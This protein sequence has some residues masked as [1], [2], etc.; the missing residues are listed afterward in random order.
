MSEVS[1]FVDALGFDPVEAGS[2]A[3]G[4]RLQPGTPLFGANTDAAT[5][6]SLLA[7]DFE[8]REQPTVPPDLR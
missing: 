7:E 5:I 1:A 4:A 2:L 8:A 6:R 3:E